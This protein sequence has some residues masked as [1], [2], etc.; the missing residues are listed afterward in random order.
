MDRGNE[1]EPT[2]AHGEYEAA[3]GHFVTQVG[4]IRHRDLAGGLLAGWIESTMTAGP[5]SRA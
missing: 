4:F 3:T 2:R 1:Q 5:K